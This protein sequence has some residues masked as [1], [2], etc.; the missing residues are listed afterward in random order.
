[1]EDP[2]K[3]ISREHLRDIVLVV[4]T[5]WLVPF[6]VALPFVLHN[7]IFAVIFAT[8]GCAVLLGLGLVVKMWDR[9][10]GRK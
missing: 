10:R 4:A 2:L 8:I 3:R 1:M 5:C 9:I 6:G 7:P